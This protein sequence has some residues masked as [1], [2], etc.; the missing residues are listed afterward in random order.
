MDV[1]A[2]ALLG[3]LLLVGVAGC[4]PSEEEAAPAPLETEDIAGPVDASVT[5]DFDVQARSETESVGAELPADFPRDVPLYPSSTV[6]NYGPA[7]TDSRFI[8]LSVASE[9]ARVESR[10]SSQLSAAGWRASEAG[11]FDRGS[12]SIVVSY[13]E[14]TP[15][16]WVRIE[17]PAAG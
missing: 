4:R 6:I 13:R 16:T 17:Y 11:R 8:E 1:R 5:T 10:Y 15:G 3:A 9:L 2:T 7:G 12:R 14:G